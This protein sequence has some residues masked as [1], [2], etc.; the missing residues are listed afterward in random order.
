LFTYH[1]GA[2][3]WRLEKV[4]GTPVLKKSAGVLR[5]SGRKAAA[6]FLGRGSEFSI[7]LLAAPSL[8]AGESRWG[9]LRGKTA[10]IPLNENDRFLQLFR[11]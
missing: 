10:G 4:L 3:A 7:R 6:A 11:R 2:P 1:L 5:A 9:F 8:G